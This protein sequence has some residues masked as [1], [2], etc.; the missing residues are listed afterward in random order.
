[1]RENGLTEVWQT[2]NKDFYQVKGKKSFLYIKNYN[3]LSFYFIYSTTKGDLGELGVLRKRG[4][5]DRLKI[6]KRI[7]LCVH[8]ISSHKKTMRIRYTF[9]NLKTPNNQY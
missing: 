8:L 1:M 2:D 7:F 6:Y 9:I 4:W 5:L 3:A